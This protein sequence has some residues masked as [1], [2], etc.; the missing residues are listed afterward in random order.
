MI[1]QL[2]LYKQQGV[3]LL[4]FAV[5]IVLAAASFAVSRLSIN[6]VKTKQLI[7][8]RLVLKEAKA[9]LIA[10]AVN[11][12]EITSAVRGPGYFLCPDTDND[13]EAETGCNGPATVA[14]LPWKT[15]GI[16]G[17]RDS[18][19]ERLWYAISQN[20]DYTSSPANKLVNTATVGSI[21][22]KNSNGVLINDGTSID[23][24][25]AV[26][27]APGAALTRLDGYP[28]N[29]NG[30][31]DN[32]IDYLDNLNGEDNAMFVHNSTNGFIEGDSNANNNE[33]ND[34]VITITYND[35]MPLIQ[36]RVAAEMQKSLNDFSDN[37]N[38]GVYPPADAG[39]F[40]VDAPQWSE[41]GCATGLLPAW[42]KKEGWHD[43]Y[44]YTQPV[45]ATDVCDD[46]CIRPL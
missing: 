33:F 3:T 38:C 15:L 1:R 4:I 14:R 39:R 37:A 9:A 12:P 20:F 7:K 6:D 11:Y 40:P 16:E 42:I 36:K 35:I 22:L 23:A 27:I 43:F 32:A 44:I 25:V 45:L 19:N 26:I 10:Y 17:L 5:I 28:Q 46:N 34:L 24:L 18:D 2:S 21:S 8:T 41:P 29:R 31:P 30:N 13:G